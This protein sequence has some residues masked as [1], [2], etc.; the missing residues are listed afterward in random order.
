MVGRAFIIVVEG[1]GVHSSDG[2][3]GVHYSDGGKGVHYS[4]GGE[5][6][7]YSGGG[8][9]VHYRRDSEISYLGTRRYLRL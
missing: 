4:G 8:K 5:G 7:H 3:E 2:G 1:K 9:G 6:V